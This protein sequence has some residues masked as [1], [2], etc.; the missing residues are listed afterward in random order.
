[1]FCWLHCTA[2]KNQCSVSAWYKL[3]LAV[4]SCKCCPSSVFCLRDDWQFT[5]RHGTSQSDTSRTHDPVFLFPFWI[6]FI[7]PGLTSITGFLLMYFLNY[8]TASYQWFSNKVVHIGM[9]GVLDLQCK[10]D[11]ALFQMT[12]V[13]KTC[14]SVI[15]VSWLFLF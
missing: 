15:L 14:T 6:Y 7:A 1:M 8:W 13:I 12:F 9:I 11:L 2:S 5:R 10:H 4:L 3:E